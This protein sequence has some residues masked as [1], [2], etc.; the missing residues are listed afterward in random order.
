MAETSGS[1]GQPNI[2]I[3]L[4]DVE[5]CDRRTF[6]IIQSSTE[7]LE[8]EE[9]GLILYPQ[10]DCL[11]PGVDKV[12]V[13]ILASIAGRYVLP[14]GYHLVSSVFWLHC[15]PNCTFVKPIK[16]QMEHCANTNDP[17]NL[18]FVKASTS[19][20]PYSFK[21]L[22]GGQFFIKSDGIDYG[23]IELSQFCGVTVGQKG[24]NDRKYYGILFYLD[25]QTIHIALTWNE[26]GHITVSYTSNLLTLILIILA[27]S[28]KGVYACSTRRWRARNCI[29][30]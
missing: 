2:E 6:E 4:Q 28:Q 10:K 23:T 16:L 30:F 20:L 22:E 21:Q 19:S 26:S 3:V 25:S 5:V 27:E 17:A 18:S 24:S 9:Y 11:P 12:T 29:G 15:L 13:N 14:D 8:W 7:P 1:C